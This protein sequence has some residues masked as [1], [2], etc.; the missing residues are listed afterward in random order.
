MSYNLNHV[1]MV[2]CQPTGTVQRLLADNFFL[3]GGGH[4]EDRVS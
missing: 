4:S 1:K 3:G 2:N